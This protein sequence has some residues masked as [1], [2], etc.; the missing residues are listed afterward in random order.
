MVLTIAVLVILITAPIGAVAIMLSA[1]K[2]L[3]KSSEEFHSAKEDTTH[4]AQGPA[5]AGRGQV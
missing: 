1:P 5:D 2:L 3:N 4:T